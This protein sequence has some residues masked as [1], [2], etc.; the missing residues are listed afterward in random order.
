MSGRRIVITGVGLVT[1][2]GVGVKNS[3]TNLVKG[4]SGLVSTKILDEYDR[5][6]KDIPSQVVG[7]VPELKDGNVNGLVFHGGESSGYWD[8]TSFLQNGEV[9]KLPRFAQYAL[10]ATKEALSDANWFPTQEDD[11]NDTGV[12]I[13]SGIGSIEDSFNNSVN[14]HEK[15][16]RKIQPLFVPKLL[17]NMASGNVSIT[18][19]F[20][21]PNHSVSTACATGVH[22]IGD[23]ARF[24]KDGYCNVM[25]A[26]ATEATIHPLALAG[27]ARAKSVVTNFNDDPTAA[28]R[29]F[30]KDR[31]GFVLSEGCGILILENLD[32]ALQRGV[33]NIYG[34]VVGY[35]LS[36]DGYHI[37]SPSPKGLGA[38]RAMEFALKQA[39]VL[40]NAIDYVNA[41]ATSTLLGD[42][43]ENQ[44]IQTIFGN[45]NKELAVSSSKGSIGHLLG[46]AGSVEAIFA[47]LAMHNNVLPPT[48]NCDSPGGAEGDDKD[49]FIFNYV[50]NKAQDKE[51]NYSM[52]NS[53]GFGGTN[54]SICF[55]K[56]K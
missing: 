13:G 38:A 47:I 33:S 29:P 10:C 6:Y 17:A 44:A 45:N 28:S 51:I 9:R 30:D 2:L 24:I 36:G 25:V 4:K 42:R 54:A 55:K 8:P 53:F 22:A 12:C 50:Q 3:W 19:G 7:K 46:A 52:S 43:A 35:G 11:L 32:H 49:N 14:F 27:F 37:T 56:I 15:G 23:A 34:E 40:P 26:G 21:G 48:L 16:Y 20:K 41:H 1:P 5:Y 18:Y 31:N 39:N